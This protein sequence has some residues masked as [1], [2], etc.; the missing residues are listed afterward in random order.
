MDEGRDTKNEGLGSI[1]GSYGSRD[2][3]ASG[4]PQIHGKFISRN[5]VFIIYLSVFLFAAL[6]IGQA[7]V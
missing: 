4:D 5:N 2:I 6:C 3:T 1:V 7:W